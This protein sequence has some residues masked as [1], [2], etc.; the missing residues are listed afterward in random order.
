MNYV[1]I[2]FMLQWEY[3]FS[4]LKLQSSGILVTFFVPFN[5]GIFVTY[6]ELFF[7]LSFFASEPSRIWTEMISLIAIIAFY[8]RAQFLQPY[9][10]IVSIFHSFSLE[11]YSI[12]FHSVT[13]QQ[14]IQIFPPSHE[15]F[16]PGFHFL[17]TWKITSGVWT[18][19]THLSYIALHCWTC[20]AWYWICQDSESWIYYSNPFYL[21]SK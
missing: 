1:E 17:I 3:Q 10:L 8:V 14:N 5:K 6:F 18:E 11:K 7:F 4:S 2:N 12:Y 21:I 16:F 19:E 20:N 13:F 15:I 9:P